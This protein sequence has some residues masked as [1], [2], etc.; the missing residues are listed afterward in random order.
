MDADQ[1][2]DRPVWPCARK[3]ADTVAAANNGRTIRKAVL[4]SAVMLAVALLFF[5]WLKRPVAGGIV[6]T[7]SLVVLVCGLFIPVAFKAIAR[8]GL[9]LGEWVGAGLTW[10]LL[11]P[12]FYLCFVP[13]RIVLAIS[14]KDPLNLAFKS[15]ATT[16]W[17]PR[18]PVKDVKRYERQH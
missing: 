17:I 14:G 16:Y 8:F 9:K 6:L 15:R 13:G 2:R 1:N 4:Q 5:L 3:A 7:L 11:V 18:T 10:L 12:F